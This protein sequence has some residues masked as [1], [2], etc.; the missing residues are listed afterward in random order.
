MK[1]NSRHIKEISTF[2]LFSYLLFLCVAIFHIHNTD[3]TIISKFISNQNESSSNNADPYLD[4][5]SKC[6]IDQFTQ[7]LFFSSTEDQI[8]NN[9]LIPEN[10]SV[11]EEQ[12]IPL[13]QVSPHF[14]LRAPPALS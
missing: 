4:D 1:L 12:K 13:R 11:Q 8:K 14:S 3:Q 6:R 10:F 7:N 5:Q 9:Q 2:L